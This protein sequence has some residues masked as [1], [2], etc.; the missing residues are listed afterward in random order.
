MNIVLGSSDTLDVLKP[1]ITDYIMKRPYDLHVRVFA[2]SIAD[3]DPV[4][5][6]L[7]VV[8]AIEV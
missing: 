6:D 4:L 3:Q 7:D 1:F 2:G 5:K 8:T